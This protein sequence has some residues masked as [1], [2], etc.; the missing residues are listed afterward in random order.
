MEFKQR[1][2]NDHIHTLLFLVEPFSKKSNHLTM[3]LEVRFMKVS[4]L[5]LCVQ[6]HRSFVYVSP[7]IA[8]ALLPKLLPSFHAGHL[9]N[10]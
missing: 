8:H 3:S 5:P 7:T 2:G 6:T 10:L 1:V 9:G 4:W